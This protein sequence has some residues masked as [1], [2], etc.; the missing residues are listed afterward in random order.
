MIS[1]TLCYHNTSDISDTLI[2][3]HPSTAEEIAA[4]PLLPA[5]T[6][7]IQTANSQGEDNLLQLVIACSTIHDNALV[8]PFVGDGGRSG[9]RIR[10]STA[11]GVDTAEPADL[12]IITD[13]G[14]SS[15]SYPLADSAL[16]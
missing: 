9:A 12:D 3:W 13:F 8:V 15:G 5:D 2:R 16:Q 10:S 1:G 4:D 11:P 7:I 14:Y 6:A